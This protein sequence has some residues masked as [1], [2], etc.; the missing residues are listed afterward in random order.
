[1]NGGVQQSF[2]R[3]SMPKW[4]AARLEIFSYLLGDAAPVDDYDRRARH[5]WVDGP[6]RPLSCGRVIEGDI[7][8]LPSGIYFRAQNIDVPPGTLA[9]PSRFGGRTHDDFLRV[10]GASA[11][12]GWQRREQWVFTARGIFL[13]AL[14]EHAIVLHGLVDSRE[15]SDGPATM[16]PIW[17]ATIDPR[18]AIYA[19][20][21]MVP[22]KFDLMFPMLNIE[23]V[24][25]W[26][27][28]L[29]PEQIRKQ[30]LNTQYQH[31]RDLAEWKK[32]NGSP[33]R[34]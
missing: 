1:M 17:I 22:D 13:H 9:E 3:T 23:E 6:T 15:M 16:E 2:G 30:I 24:K 12:D 11:F 18:T 26:P 33:H 25:A 8:Q 32:L 31:M 28:M 4:R 10:I 19:A 20:A 34:R 21:F 29:P 14:R 27:E 5:Y 7:D